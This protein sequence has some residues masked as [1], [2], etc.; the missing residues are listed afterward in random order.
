MVE[1]KEDDGRRYST[2]LFP[3][4]WVRMSKLQSELITRLISASPEDAEAIRQQVR[5][6]EMIKDIPDEL[7]SNTGD[8]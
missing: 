5:G 7:I 6:I 2:V 3:D 8:E 1:I 4:F